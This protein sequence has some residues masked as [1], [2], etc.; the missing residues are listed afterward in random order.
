MQLLAASEEG[1][2]TS[3]A[4]KSHAVYFVAILREYNALGHTV[5]YTEMSTEELVVRE[6]ISTEES[7]PSV[8]A[9]GKD[10][11]T[12]ELPFTTW[13][14][15]VVP[16]APFAG[17]AGRAGSGGELRLNSIPVNVTVARLT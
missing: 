5:E 1:I 6:F 7:P 4:C 15:R 9:I 16:Y 10:V 11:W 8:P 14:K 17:V 2:N 12:L 3:T 13:E